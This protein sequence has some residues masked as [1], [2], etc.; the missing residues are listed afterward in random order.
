VRTTDVWNSFTTA[1]RMRIR[2]MLRTP[3]DMRKLAPEDDQRLLREYWRKHR[4]R[5][6][7][8]L[9][10]LDDHRKNSEYRK[11]LQGLIKK[12]EDVSPNYDR[13]TYE[14]WRKEVQCKS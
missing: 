1:E 12:G 8:Q 2:A 7:D 5:S 3:A 11:W 9:P 14:R 13:K 4:R 10:G 6:R